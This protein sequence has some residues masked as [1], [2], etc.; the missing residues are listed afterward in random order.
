MNIINIAIVNSTSFDISGLKEPTISVPSYLLDNQSPEVIGLYSIYDSS[1]SKIKISQQRRRAYSYIGRNIDSLKPYDGTKNAAE[2][3]TL[4]MP[5]W[6]L[7]CS[8]EN[9]RSIHIDLCAAAYGIYDSIDNILD[10]TTMQKTG[11]APVYIFD[12]DDCHLADIPNISHK[13][14]LTNTKKLNGCNALLPSIRH[15]KIGHGYTEGATG[16]GI[17]PVEVFNKRQID[18]CSEIVKQLHFLSVSHFASILCD[19]YEPNIMSKELRQ[20]LSLDEMTIEIVQRQALEIFPN[21]AKVKITGLTSDKG[22]LLNGRKGRITKNLKL[23]NTYNEVRWGVILDSGEEI[24]VC[25]NN[26]HPDFDYK[27]IEKANMEELRKMVNDPIFSDFLF[28]LKN[29]NGGFT[30]IASPKFLP[31]LKKSIEGGIMPL[32]KEY[33]VTLSI[34]NHPKG[35]AFRLFMMKFRSG[36]S[37]LEYADA[38]EDP[39]FKESYEKLLGLGKLKMRT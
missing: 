30:T 17:T 27:P 25:H 36:I 32:T 5:H 1:T 39:F 6:W 10:I 19:G 24:S 37:G 11:K 9:K 38:M 29:G 8:L 21:D 13:F 12:I 2:V 20:Y 15:L 34:A 23:G 3:D 4:T 35:E 16:L 31:Y 26:L 14:I 33:E 28:Q 7:C 22:K 18:A